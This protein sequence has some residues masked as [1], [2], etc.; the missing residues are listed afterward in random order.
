MGKSSK[1]TI[2]YRHYMTLYMGEGHEMDYL[3]EVQVGGEVAWS[4]HLEGDGVIEID[5]AY[6]FGGDKKEGGVVGQL[7]VRSGLP[8]Q[9]PHPLLESMRPGPWPAARGLCTTVFD[10]QVGAMN[11]YIKLW[12]KRWG[13][14]ERG[15]D[16]DV[17]QPGLLKIG[18]GMN[19]IHIIYNLLTNRAFGRGY[20][21]EVI[22]ETSFLQAAQ[23]LFDEQFGLC[24]TYRRSEPVR[25]FIA[26]ISNHV[27]GQWAEDPRTGKI[28]YRLYRPDYDAA[29]LPLL[30]ESNILRL[31]AW[32]LGLL[33]SGVNEVTAVGRDVLTN[34]DIA[35]TYQNLAG[36]QAQGRVISQKLQFPG[37][38]NR[39]LLA[40]IAAREV[41]SA[42]FLLSRIRLTVDRRLWGVKRG[43]V[44]ALSWARRGVVRMPVRVLSVDEGTRTDSQIRL[45]L[46]QDIFGM[47]QTT[48]IQ[49]VETGWTAPP[50][51]PQPVPVQTA[52]EASYRDLAGSLR[53][54][55]L[56]ALEA[57][58]GYLV[59]LGA[60]PAGVAY[61]YLLQTRVAPAAFEEVAAG[62]FTPTGTLGAS[63]GPASTTFTL[64]ASSGLDLV[65][66]GTAVIVG[67]EVCKLTA[68]NTGTG[69]CTVERG[70]VDTVPVSHAAGTRVWFADT[71]NGF[72]P[73]ERIDGEAVDAKLLTR[74]ARGVLDPGAAPTA[75]VTFDSRQARPYPPGFL[76]VNGSAYPTTIAG[77]LTITWQH[78]DRLQQQDQL[79]GWSASSI[80]PEPGTTYTLRLYD[81]SGVLR[82]TVSGL[83]TTSYTWSTESQDSGLGVFS[84]VTPA[85]WSQSSILSGNATYQATVAKMADGLNTTGASTNNS[86]LPW[87]R[88]DLGG[89]F[90]GSISRI[91][92][93]AG[94]LTGFG[95]TALYINERL[96]Q[97]SVDGVSGWTTVATITGVTDSGSL[98]FFDFPPV[99]TRWWRIYTPFTSVA[100]AT[101][102][103][104]YTLTAGSL[105]SQVRFELESV[106]EGLQSW[107]KHGWTVV[108]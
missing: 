35:V 102:L 80:G 85:A 27:G 108:R 8:G 52:Y 25:N 104:F 93:A 74:T 94:N 59:T 56:A 86:S 39:E 42:S 3:S 91:G 29:S 81:Q 105:N 38:W 13:R 50:T 62:D 61:N 48:Y 101:E 9:L 30:D 70:C 6:L 77:N 68:I 20:P 64:S 49:P 33:D 88:A 22:D 32:N 100:V 57:D 97:Y 79:I 69:A 31:E 17:W 16:G 5:Q 36:V 53:A 41:A 63:I 55:D 43:D 58:A 47:P 46:V 107:T 19:P 44:F 82:R 75:S 72:D 78:R 65:E 73:T 76:R 1:P 40:R 37:A 103:R 92:V 24:L 99:S 11:P 18:R 60:R 21:R 34:K 84:E 67:S 90:L 66:L 23:T 106:R 12:S 95:N 83:T 28:T 10:G 4:G 98:F 45:T 2:G 96:L 15:W 26:I 87:I 51:T 14:F 89:T 54:A 71:Y 7:T